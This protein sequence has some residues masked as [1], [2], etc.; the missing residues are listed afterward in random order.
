M[1]SIRKELESILDTVELYQESHYYLDINKLKKAFHPNAHIVGY[2][3]G[4][5]TFDS[6]DQY[7]EILA[8]E[9]SSAELGEK[10]Y[11][12]LLSLDK[13]DT[14]VMVKIE[15]L[16]SGVRYISQLSMLKVDNNWQI[17][18]GLFHADKG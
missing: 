1:K 18:N 14:T 6:R 15:S 5:Q 12:K 8:A 3:E 9:K 4:E 13:T 16:I 2:Y 7:I 17:I 10:P 11:I